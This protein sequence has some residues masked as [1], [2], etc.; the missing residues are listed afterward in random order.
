M[1]ASL[2]LPPRSSNSRRDASRAALFVAASAASVLLLVPAATADDLNPPTYRGDLRSTSAEW[3]FR[4]DQ[5]PGPPILPDGGTVPLVVGDA[6]AQMDSAFPEGAPHPSGATFGDVSWS[7][8]SNG[9]YRGGPGDD[10]VLVFNVPNWIDTEPSKRLRLQVTYAGPAPATLV[11]GF[12]GVP[13]TGDGV[14]ELL[15]DRLDIASS[16]QLPEG[17]SYFS[18]DWQ[19]LPNPDW[20]QVVL[21]L[22][23]GTFV[24]QVVIDT[25]SDAT[26]DPG[27]LLWA[28]FET[29]DTSQWSSG[30]R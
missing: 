9:G 28:D 2:L 11:I 29:G 4:T 7:A 14:T 17:M 25:V 6:A 27:F 22:H 13:G 3:D 19:V 8:A 16:N 10:G 21:Y 5:S 26:K 12:L 20:E 18:E 15:V 1:H 30:G 23:E 24:D